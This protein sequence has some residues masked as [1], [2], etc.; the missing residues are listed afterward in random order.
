MKGRMF[1]KLFHQ[2][3]KMRRVIYVCN[4]VDG[5]ERTKMR[6]WQREETGTEFRLNVVNRKEGDPFREDLVWQYH[7]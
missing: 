2:C 5:K 1:W 4:K 7:V 6:H 3:V